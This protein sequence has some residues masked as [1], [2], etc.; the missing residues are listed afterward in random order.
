MNSKDLTSND[1]IINSTYATL[2]AKYQ[3]LYQFVM[4]YSEYIY[5]KHDYLENQRPLT[6]LEVHTLSYIEDN[7]GVTATQLITYWNKTKGAISQILSKLE[8]EE[9]ITKQTTAT[10]A[11]TKHLYITEKGRA[12]SKS[13]KI[14]DILDTN[15]TMSQILEHCTSAEVDTFFKVI[16]A[17]NEVIKKDF[18][19]K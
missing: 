10:N 6:M 15:R 9:L 11:K 3:N 13:H 7:P 5:S 12:I 1:E 18:V 2:N 4:N 16:T 8:K 14:F 19:K 17:Y